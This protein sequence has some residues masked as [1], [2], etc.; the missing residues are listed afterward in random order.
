L[1]VSPWV[2]LQSKIANPVT[3]HSYQR[4]GYHKGQKIQSH[5]ST[6][7]RRNAGSGHDRFFALDLSLPPNIKIFSIWV[8]IFSE[9]HQDCQVT[10]RP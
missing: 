7:S 10:A 1:V 2:N 3:L 5:N 6:D 8:H 4:T 9:I